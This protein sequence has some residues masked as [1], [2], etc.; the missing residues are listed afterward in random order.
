MFK[1][2]KTGSKQTQQ[3]SN[4]NVP[5]THYILIFSGLKLWSANAKNSNYWFGRSSISTKLQHPSI[6]HLLGAWN[7]S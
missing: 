3:R 5:C 7:P 4:N 1:C 6:G 2:N